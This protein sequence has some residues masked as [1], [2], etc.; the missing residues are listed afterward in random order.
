MT[1]RRHRF[2]SKQSLPG[3]HDVVHNRLTDYT[4]E[5][6][7]VAQLWR[8]A[9]RCVVTLAALACSTLAI[10]D[11]ETVDQ[12]TVPNA[13][14]VAADGYPPCGAPLDLVPLLGNAAGKIVEALVKGAQI[15]SGSVFAITGPGSSASGTG[16]GG[17]QLL[18]R[19][20]GTQRFASCVRMAVVI[21]SNAH[22]TH[23]SFFATEGGGYQHDPRAGCSAW[24]PDESPKRENT[25]LGPFRC[26]IGSAGFDDLT[27]VQQGAVLVVGCVFRTWSDDR[28]RLAT[29]AVDWE[30]RD[31]D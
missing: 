7:A 3:E 27:F 13:R 4:G 28:Q 8:T 29:M 24:H 12:W 19:N 25:A 20:V 18:E 22:V 21:P 11:T 31:A 2:A 17:A 6:M 5:A 15:P 14:Y 23:V 9:S 30:Y 16:S 26:S 10:A 1:V